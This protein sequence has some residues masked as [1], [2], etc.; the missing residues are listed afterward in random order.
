MVVVVVVVVVVFPS[1]VSVVLSLSRLVSFASIVELSISVVVLSTSLQVLLYIVF[2][3]F[4]ISY[5]LE[6][7]LIFLF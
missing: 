4:S 2:A 7:C 6:W 1:S 3:Y 5:L